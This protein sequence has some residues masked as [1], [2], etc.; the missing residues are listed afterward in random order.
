MNES[1]LAPEDNSVAPQSY[2]AEL[3]G[4][5]KPFK[6]HE[7]LAKGKWESNNYIKILERQLDEARNDV[8][9][10]KKDSDTKANLQTLVDKLETQYKQ[11]T[12]SAQPQANVESPRPVINSLDEYKSLA[13]SEYE[14]IR[15]QEK[16]EQNFAL[17]KNKLKE[18][19][20]DKATDV[21]KQHIET[22]GISQARLDEMARVE[23]QVLIRAM[24]LD[25]P[26]PQPAYQAPPRSSQRSDNFAPTGGEKRTWAYYQKL[27]K[28][29]PELKYDPK[30]NISMHNDMLKLGRD[31]EDGDFHK[32]N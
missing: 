27:L 20:G 16:Q 23:P 15:T 11:A 18:R 26:P 28:E 17:V 7:S 19:Y 12:N 2:L 9:S 4:D 6:D 30:T 22:L 31:F 3:V 14:A 13:R 32:Y 10:Y 25:T 1:L 5:N 29:K 21:V 24:G 8:L